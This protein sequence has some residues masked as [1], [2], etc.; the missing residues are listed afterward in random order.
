MIGNIFMLSK[1]DSFFLVFFMFLKIVI[2]AMTESNLLYLNNIL[3]QLLW[4][5]LISIY[6]FY[7]RL[8]FALLLSFS[9]YPGNRFWKGSFIS[10]HLT[11]RLTVVPLVPR[12]NSVWS[13][14]FGYEDFV[15]LAVEMVKRTNNWTNKQ[16]MEIIKLI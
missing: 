1:T 9:F 6:Y 5:A 10:R 13:T 12:L 16:T 8:I 7:F 4:L 3:T 11:W 14:E 15:I 2:T